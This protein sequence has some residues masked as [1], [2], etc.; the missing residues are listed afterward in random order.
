MELIVK[1]SHVSLHAARKAVSSLGNI[2]EN[3]AVFYFPDEHRHRI[4]K[5]D[6]VGQECQEIWRRTRLVRIFLNDDSCLR[7][8]SAVLMEIAETWEIGM[9]NFSFER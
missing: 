7:L 4:C 6:R 2:L 8:V 1:G 5:V 3:L 9:I